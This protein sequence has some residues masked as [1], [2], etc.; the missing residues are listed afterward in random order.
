MKS[1][2]PLLSLSLCLIP[3]ASH[4]RDTLY[5]SYSSSRARGWSISARG[6]CNPELI[7]VGR[8]HRR[9]WRTILSLFPPEMEKIVRPRAESCRNESSLNCERETLN[10]RSVQRD[11]RD[12]SAAC[13]RQLCLGRLF[14]SQRIFKRACVRAPLLRRSSTL[15]CFVFFF[16]VFRRKKSWWFR[17]RDVDWEEKEEERRGG[18]SGNC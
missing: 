18:G 7:L 1:V 8:W 9:A 12:T 17:A 6:L 16:L 3:I 5:T 15:L 13:T 2:N 4:I 14:Q 11:R 10:A